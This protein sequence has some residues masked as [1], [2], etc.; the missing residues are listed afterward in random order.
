VGIVSKFFQEKELQMT[1]TIR[2][3]TPSLHAEHVPEDILAI[4]DKMNGCRGFRSTKWPSKILNYLINSYFNDP[5]QKIQQYDLA[6]DVFGKNAD[7]DPSHDPLVRIH[8]GRLRRTLEVYYQNEGQNDSLRLRVPTGQYN[9]HIETST[10]DNSD[11]TDTNIIKNEATHTKS[12]VPSVSVTVNSE[13][14]EFLAKLLCTTLHPF[15]TLN[16]APF[17][18]RQNTRY[19]IDLTLNKT[20]L[21]RGILLASLNDNLNQHQLWSQSFQI[22]MS[23]VFDNVELKI[24]KIANQIADETGV[25]ATLAHRH[26]HLNSEVFTLGMSLSP[27]MGNPRTIEQFTQR[28]NH[29]IPAPA[30]CSISKARQSIVALD[31]FTLNTPLADSYYILAYNLAQQAINADPH[32]I[33][34]QMAM[35]YLSLINR[36]IDDLQSNARQ[37][38]E[39]KPYSAFANMVC[40]F[41]LYLSGAVNE[42]LRLIDHGATLNPHYPSWLNMAYFIDSYR[43]GNYRNAYQIAKTID[44]QN[45]YLGP[46]MRAIS[47]TK[48][49]KRRFALIEVQKLQSI[50]K[51]LATN[52]ELLLSQYL[53]DDDLV[54]AMSQDLRQALEHYKHSQLSNERLM[55]VK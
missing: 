29:Y 9:L 14:Y 21:E 51:N 52:I 47:C 39:S 24:N 54:Q 8:M 53:L 35:C 18:L 12:C 16:V 26:S 49:N 19:T 31:A 5:T 33:Y 37:I 42:G 41:W 55:L 6:F 28:L 13:S 2:L 38:L 32:C 48:L 23:N 34:A 25:I 36:D 15:A 27:L 7:F 17:G 30:N 4:L 40:G 1:T 22:Q 3:T 20:S 43:N 45:L 44:S 50:D 46:M 11:N 10:S